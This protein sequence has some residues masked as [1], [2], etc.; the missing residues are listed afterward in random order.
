MHNDVVCDAVIQGDFFGSVPV[1]SLERMLCQKTLAQ[2]KC[3]VAQ[4]DLSGYIF[5][6]DADA[7]ASL[8]EF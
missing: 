6:M 8:L 2:I 4:I 7:F 1:E 3:D 5:G